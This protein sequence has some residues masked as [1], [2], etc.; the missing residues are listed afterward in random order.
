[1]AVA[2]SSKVF[3]EYNR[4]V[5]KADITTGV[6]DP[7][8][9][10]V[11]LTFPECIPERIDVATRMQEIGYLHD[12]MVDAVNTPAESRA[13]NRT[14]AD[15]YGLEANSALLSHAFKGIRGK[16]QMEAK[17]F[18]QAIAIDRED[19][20]SV[21]N[22]WKRYLELEGR[23]RMANEFVSLDEWIPYRNEDAAIW[24]T[25]EIARF[26]AGVKV[27]EEEKLAVEHIV[28]P[29]LTVASLV[30]DY[31]SY[32]KEYTVYLREDG[33]NGVANSI[34]VLMREYGINKAEAKR[35]LAQKITALEQEYLAAR[36]SYEKAN[37]NLSQRVKSWIDAAVFIASGS[38]YWSTYSTRFHRPEYSGLAPIRS[39]GPRDGTI[40]STS[41]NLDKDTSSVQET[42]DI[43]DRDCEIQLEQQLPS[44]NLSPVIK[45]GLQTP[46][47]DN[48]KILSFTDTRER[49]ILAE[50]V[51]A[52]YEYLCSLGSKGV[53]Q[54]A[55]EALNIWLDVPETSLSAIRNIVD[56]LHSSSLM[57]D[58]IQD[59]SALRRGSPATHLLFGE[60]QTINS[61]N[62]LFVLSL[63]ELRKLHHPQSTA[64]YNAQL[65][66]LHIGQSMDLYWTRHVACPT[67]SEYVDMVDYKT[68]G[69][70]NLV[71][72]LMQAEGCC[73]EQLRLNG[74]MTLL[75]RYFQ[76]RDDYNNL[77]STDYTA[78]KGFCEDLDEGKFSLPLIH[79]LQISQKQKHRLQDILQERRHNGGS[80]CVEMK[81]LVLK[82]L[83]DG[84][85]LEYVRQVL[86]ELE[87]AIDAEIRR[88]EEVVGEENF[89]MRLLV[90]RLRV[91]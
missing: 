27:S 69:L 22:K 39:N 73:G 91:N 75:G 60:A 25:H 31:Y 51:Q 26:V 14:F 16:R 44:N 40:Q 84:G 66:R 47:S 55:I 33:T 2:T 76:I 8:G 88:V 64:I 15:S 48:E 86:E 34:W 65:R 3:E 46:V 53:R 59:Q 30:N 50:I 10:A 12:N 54:A 71:G 70:F 58:D 35:L 9:H 19:A 90:E 6:C 49:D 74:M 36:E 28:Y 57:L 72:G 61:A 38:H 13:L 89:V 80:M 21:M 18:L 85:S 83:R 81:D 56:Y 42:P 77:V 7:R 79:A 52:P 62:F 5:G 17:M 32:E 37:P 1:M 87:D 29:V 11:S 23:A 68:G 78:A 45:S 41:P 67:V 43:L 20:L 24:L 4:L 63:E 82:M